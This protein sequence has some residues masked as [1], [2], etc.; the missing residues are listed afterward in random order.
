MTRSATSIRNEIPVP[1][2]SLMDTLHAPAAAGILLQPE[3]SPANLGIIYRQ[4]KKHDTFQTN[5][6][7]NKINKKNKNLISYLLLYI[8]LEKADSCYAIDKLLFLPY[9]SNLP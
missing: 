6:Q 3:F 9:V 2:Q 5:I 1:F 7:I 4:E 8:H